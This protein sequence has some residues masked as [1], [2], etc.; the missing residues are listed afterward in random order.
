MSDSRLPDSWSG[1]SGAIGLKLPCAR[2]SAKRIVVVGLGPRVDLPSRAEGEQLDVPSTLPHGAASALAVLLRKKDRSP[3]LR[4]CSGQTIATDVRH[5]R[6][7]SRKAA[8]AMNAA[9]LREPDCLWRRREKDADRPIG[10]G[11]AG[12][13]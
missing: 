4:P 6:R 8:A 7:R 3:P 13:F 5:G 11:G 12:A 1:S 2:G 10:I 9:P